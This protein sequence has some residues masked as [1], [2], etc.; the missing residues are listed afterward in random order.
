MNYEG[1]D[2][3]KTDR[4]GRCIAR[5]TVSHGYAGYHA[6]CYRS[7]SCCTCADTGQD[8]SWSRGIAGAAIGYCNG[9]YCAAGYG[10]RGAAGAVL[11]HLLPGQVNLGKISLANSGK[12]TRNQQVRI[13]VLEND[14]I[15]IVCSPRCK[16]GNKR[17]TAIVGGE[18]RYFILK[19]G[20][21]ITHGPQVG[22][23]IVIDQRKDV[24]TA[25]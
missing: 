20:F 12:R 2:D 18:G 21:I 15:G 8:D 25:I 4:R 19:T 11:R 17:F 9:C 13:G 5:T 14:I 24:G 3:G 22:P 7:S 6:A 16:T 23:L 1:R 10:S